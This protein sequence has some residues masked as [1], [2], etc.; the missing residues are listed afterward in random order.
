M[1]KM[2][3]LL[4]FLLGVNTYIGIDYCIRKSY[5]IG[6]KD[7]M[8]ETVDLVAKENDTDVRQLKMLFSNNCDEKA[9]DFKFTE[10]F[11]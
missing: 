5:S 3:C 4:W 2:K 11:R 9:K 8:L 6:C 1:N 7:D 10:L